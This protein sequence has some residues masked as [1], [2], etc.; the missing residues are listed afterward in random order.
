M[1]SNLV[2]TLK[3]WGLPKLE[4]RVGVLSLTNRADC[5]ISRDR[6]EG[7]RTGHL[8]GVEGRGEYI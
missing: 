4:N 7:V 2:C 3:T 5:A 8:R 6:N 1:C